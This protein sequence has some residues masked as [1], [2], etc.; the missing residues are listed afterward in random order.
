MFFSVGKSDVNGNKENEDEEF[1][2][3]EGV[4]PLP[5]SILDKKE[6]VIIQDRLDRAQFSSRIEAVTEKSSSVK[7]A[8]DQ[9]GNKFEE[10]RLKVAQILERDDSI[11]RIFQ[12][13]VKIGNSQDM[14]DNQKGGELD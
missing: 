3:F 8:A 5:S 4:L 14:I 6:R 7:A 2:V 10:R 13:K 12:K 9:V 1:D 11:Q